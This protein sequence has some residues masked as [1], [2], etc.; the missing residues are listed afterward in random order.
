M[1]NRRNQVETKYLDDEITGDTYRRQSEG[2]GE[3]L[4]GISLELSRLNLSRESN[5]GV[6]EQL[7]RL[8]DRL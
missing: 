3:A 8:S 1:E 5:I 2:I 6:F 7:M 4:L